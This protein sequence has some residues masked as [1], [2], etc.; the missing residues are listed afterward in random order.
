MQKSLSKVSS[1]DAELWII[2]ATA[3][4]FK[5]K[6]GDTYDTNHYYRVGS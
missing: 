4:K 1:C 2:I 6:G 3:T 5:M